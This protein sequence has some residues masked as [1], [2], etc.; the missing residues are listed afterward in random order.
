MVRLL[1]LCSGDPNNIK[2]FSGSAKSLISALEK[3]GI[4]HAKA[5]VLKG[6]S[7]GFSP[8]PIWLKIFRKIDLLH[9]EPL[10]RHSELIYKIDSIRAHKIAKKN[11]GF[12]ACLM[13]GTQFN[14][15]LDVPT[16]CYFDATAV[17]VLKSGLWQ[18]SYLPDRAKK[19]IIDRQQELF[20]NCF[21]VFPRTNWAAK[22]LFSKYNIKSN[23]VVVAGAGANFDGSWQPFPH[24][25]YDNK[26]ILFVGGDWEGKGGPFIIK[27]FQKVRQ[28]IPEAHLVIV[29]CNPAIDIDGVEVVGRID[30][31]VPGGLELLLK[32]YARAS[33]F[34]I[35][36]KFEAFGIVA[37]E[38]QY[39]F[40][41]CVLPSKFAFPEMIVNNST[42]KLLH[43]ENV[44]DFA[45]ILIR[46]L[47]DPVKLKK[48][49]QAA[50][51]F[52]KQNYSWD[53]AAKRI[54]EKIEHDLSKGFEK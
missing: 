17:D 48:M 8:A 29:C 50:H 38:A 3:R 4:V 36:S 37:I 49:G 30:K 21:G 1:I 34:T 12:N 46:L 25:D 31:N 51:D 42:G 39:C 2:T 23:K 19:R 5:N 7:D 53:L 22:S 15:N 32:Q 52:V 47:K 28:P 40:V 33:V 14:P 10:L 18:I 6:I 20:N 24:E 45:G 43:H 26:I 44:D 13:Y 27:A 16:Y 9:K 35:M 54:H 11:I 41:P